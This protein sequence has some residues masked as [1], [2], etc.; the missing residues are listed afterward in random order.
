[1]CPSQQRLSQ[2]C[3]LI[4]KKLN[5]ARAT[6]MNEHHPR[7]HNN[8]GCILLLTSKTFN[9][10]LVWPKATLD[11]L[12]WYHELLKICSVVALKTLQELHLLSPVTIY[13]EVKLW[14][15]VL[16]LRIPPESS[17][18]S[19]GR[20]NP[21]S[22]TPPII[23]NR[24]HILDVMCN[25][26]PDMTKITTSS[27]WGKILELD[28]DLWANMHGG[29]QLVPWLDARE[30]D[31]RWLVPWEEKLPQYWTIQECVFWSEYALR[32]LNLQLFRSWLNLHISKKFL[33]CLT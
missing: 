8:V 14:R 32:D 23:A 20:A 7:S 10:Q 30:L 6:N 29:A 22:P 19:V 15:W 13:C 17:K 31:Q 2:T 33:S 11:R 26:L 25:F 1:M 21:I 12:N 24:L 5:D 18:R 28:N 4:N 9:L 16:K 27:L 3:Q